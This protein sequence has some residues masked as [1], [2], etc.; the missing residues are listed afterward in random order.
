M[1]SR[2]NRLIEVRSRDVLHSVIFRRISMTPL[3]G[4]HQIVA[5]EL[6]LV[7]YHNPRG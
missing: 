4:A 6:G 3:S 1:S 5:S 2:M 7:S